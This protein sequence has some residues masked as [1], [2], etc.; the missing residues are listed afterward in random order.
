MDFSEK[1]VVYSTTKPYSTLNTRTKNTKNVWFV[2]H[3]MGYLS[4]YFIRYFQELNPEENY[5]VAAQAPSLY[6]QG[7][8][9]KH[10]GANWLTKENTQ[11]ET[12]N[13]MCYFDA[14]FKTEK[15]DSNLNLIVFGFSQGVSV[16]ARY[17]AKRKLQCAQLILHSGGIPNELK[18]EDFA[19]LK[20]KVS[21]VY[22]TN[23]S[24]LNVERIAAETDKAKML[25]KDKLTVIPF[26]GRHE[27]NVKIIRSLS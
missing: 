1:H 22:G 17:V 16:A 23:D 14:I 26:D 9:F 27:V 21:L 4:R 20:A 5:I 15:L 2:C 8:N 12:S 10:V 7:N 25:F 6:Y 13:V 18:A 19:F 11:Q 24:Y 3:G